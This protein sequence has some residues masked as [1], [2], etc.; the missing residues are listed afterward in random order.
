MMTALGIVLFFF[1][2]LVSIAW[3]EL[4]HFVTARWFGIK[5][6]EFMVG[7]GRTIFSRKVG[8]TEFGLKAVPLGGYIRMIGM[9]PPAK[10]ET[11]GR[12]RRTGPFQGLIDDARQQSAM[13]VLPEDADRQFYL[14]APWKRIIVMSA[15][16]IMNLILAVVLFAIVLMGIGIPTGSTTT[17]SAVSA[18]VVPAS[19]ASQQCPPGAPPTPAAA[20][21]FQAGDK[22]V[23]FNG[24]PFGDQDWPRLQETIRAASGTVTV[25]VERGGQ[26]LDLRPTLITTELPSL[27]DENATVQA[28]FLGLSPVRFYERQ[29]VAAVGA[30]ISSIVARTGEAIVQLPSRVP[31][32]FGSVFLGQE[33]DINGPVG[34]V[35]AS[36]I[37]GEILALDAPAAAELSVFLQLLAAVNVSLFLFNL[38]PI[39]PLDG[40]QIFPAI[41][42][43]IKRRAAKL[44]GRPDPGPVDVAK[45]MPVA[46]VVALVFIA[47]SG[48]IL[49]ADVINPIRL[50]Q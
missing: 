47:W 1:G 48:L 7:F 35:G 3:H 17:V 8:E 5:V 12:S 39:P 44:L 36:R 23:A 15:G 4:G 20:A 24:Q 21:G 14:R 34:I 11:L 32:L 22:I 26:R 42:E 31:G 9:I 6:P 19:A 18:C 25:T 40:G 27:T 2:I 10:G 50:P 30:E 46:Y 38:L 43:S 49:V 28:S 29:N 37:G 41:W 16:P 45:L 33:R 13:D